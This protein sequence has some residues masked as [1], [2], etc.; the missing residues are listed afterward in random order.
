MPSGAF[1]DGGRVR[2]AA[3]LVEGLER[4]VAEAGRGPALAA[5]AVWSGMPARGGRDLVAVADGDDGEP[6]RFVL[7]GLQQIAHHGAIAL[8]EDVQ[9]K[10]ES[11]EQHRVQRE[12]RQPDGGHD[13]ASLMAAG[14][15][16]SAVLTPWMEARAARGR[17]PGALRRAVP[18]TGRSGSSENPVPGER[19]R[20]RADQAELV[21]GVLPAL[22][23]DQDVGQQVA[24]LG[25]PRVGGRRSAA[26]TAIARSAA[27]SSRSRGTSGPPPSVR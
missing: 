9:R 6:A 17:P 13:A 10:H 14:A 8:L 11:R 15:G 20:V 22:Q 4:V 2:D 1:P 19:R 27:A 12:E 24:H 21:Q 7:G 23:P 26:E 25:R 16:A 3:H 5:A 18:G